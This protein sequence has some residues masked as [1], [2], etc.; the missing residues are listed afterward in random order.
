VP[1]ILEKP[2]SGL[3]KSLADAGV[4]TISRKRVWEGPMDGGPTGGITQS[5]LGKF[6]V[7]REMFRIRVIEG[8]DSMD[9]FSHRLEYGNMW[10]VCEEHNHAGRDWLKPLQ[11]Y[12]TALMQRYKASHGDINHWYEIC[13]RQF[14]AYLKFWKTQKEVGKRASVMQ[15]QVFQ[16]PYILPY[17]GRLVYLKGKWDGAH[18]LSGCKTPKPGLWLDENKT[19]G[20][21]DEQALVRQLKFDLQTMFYLIAF[22]KYADIPVD[23]KGDPMNVCGV[24][25]NVIRRP[26][27]GGKGSIKQR[28]PTK[29]N[30]GGDSKKD[31]Y[32][33]LEKEYL[34][35]DPKHFF[36]RWTVEISQRDIDVFRETCLDPILEQLC[37][38]WEAMQDEWD[39]KSLGDY[40]SYQNF[41]FPYG[42]YNPISEGKST[43]YD[44]FMSMG[45]TVGLRR[46]VP[47]FGEL[48]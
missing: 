14:P 37:D 20:D 13:K 43:G 33:R 9:S 7:C 32:D 39:V 46:N 3:S 10:H 29:K 36:M 15:E 44:E 2:K 24:R 31:L 41:R 17:S 18:I 16:V 45:S 25:Y 1:S 26:L 47:L 23:K 27:S 38:W 6:L 12:C 35:A 40:R 42:I 19:K 30:P 28:K 4:K 5:L 21:I 48:Q 34:L 11:T 8:L 22:Q